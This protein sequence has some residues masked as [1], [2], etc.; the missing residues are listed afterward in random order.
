MSSRLSYA[1]KATELVKSVAGLDLLLRLFQA[2]AQIV[3]DLQLEGKYGIQFGAA[4]SQL[5]LGW[6]SS[7]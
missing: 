4:T 3:A 7:N 1:Q 5:A 6:Y 2:V